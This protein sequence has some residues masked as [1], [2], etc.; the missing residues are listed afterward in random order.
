[1]F[2]VKHKTRINFNLD[3]VRWYFHLTGVHFNLNDP[4]LDTDDHKNI[5]NK[6]VIIRSARRKSSLIN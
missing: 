4:Y 6:I 3:S 2:N 1:M 5:K